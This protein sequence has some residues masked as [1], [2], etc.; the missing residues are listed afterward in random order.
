MIIKLTSRAVDQLKQKIN[1]NMI[2]LKYDFD[3]CGCVV[4]GVTHL[5]EISQIEEGYEVASNEQNDFTIVFQ[6]QYEWVYDEMMTIDFL[7]EANTFL[8]K[9]DNQIFNPRMMIKKV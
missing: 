4:S 7:E 6:K 9:S 2:A 5:E 3:G 8:L 1:S